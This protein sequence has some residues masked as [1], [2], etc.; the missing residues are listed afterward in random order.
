MLTSSTWED[1]HGALSHGCLAACACAS[2]HLSFLSHVPG[3]LQLL[4]NIEKPPV[5]LYD[6]LNTSGQ[7]KSRIR[8]TWAGYTMESVCL[9]MLLLGTSAEM[10]RMVKLGMTPC[11]GRNCDFH[12]GFVGC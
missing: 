8:C 4:W 7:F 10:T 11:Q 12:Q 5:P 2:T 1:K 9:V 3:A 6:F